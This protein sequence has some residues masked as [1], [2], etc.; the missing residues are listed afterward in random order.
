MRALAGAQGASG[1]C[2]HLFDPMRVILVGN[3][4]VSCAFDFHNDAD[5]FHDSNAEFGSVNLRDDIHLTCHF[6]L[7][8][9]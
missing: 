7:I 3:I 1:L 4:V 9:I 5:A 2:E 8:L 6:V